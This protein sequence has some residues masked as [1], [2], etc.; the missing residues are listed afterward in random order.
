[1]VKAVVA[2]APRGGVRPMRAGHGARTLIEV[3]P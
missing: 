3:A 1:M 2:T